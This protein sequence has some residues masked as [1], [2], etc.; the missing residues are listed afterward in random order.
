MSRL[1]T[2]ASGDLVE[3]DANDAGNGQRRR[4]PPWR[5]WTRSTSRASTRSTA[6]LPWEGAEPGDTLE[7]GL[8]DFQP[9]DW[10]WTGVIFPG[11]GLLADEFTD[12]ALRITRLDGNTGA[13]ALASASRSR[14]SAASSAWLRPTRTALDDPARVL[15][16]HGHATPRAGSTLYLPVSAQVASSP[17]GDGHAAQGDGEVCGTAIE[18]LDARERSPDCP[19]GLCTSRPPEFQTAGPIADGHEHGPCYADGRGRAGPDGR[20]PGRRAADDRLPRT[21]ARPGTDRRLHALQRDG[22][23]K[24]SEIV[25]MPELDR[26]MYFPLGP[27]LSRCSRPRGRRRAPHRRRSSIQVAGRGLRYCR[28]ICRSVSGRGT[29]PRR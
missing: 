29:A 24:I 15:R 2:V 11:F 6:R 22:D 5:T 28:R 26:P 23:L 4:P 3:F 1:A 21:L 17:L 27:G 19:Q 10:G 13:P 16:E 12:Q 25:D 20:G 9:A 14:R 8:L 18:T 7:I